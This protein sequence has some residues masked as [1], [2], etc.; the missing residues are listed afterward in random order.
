M[1]NRRGEVGP[2]EVLVA[3]IIIGCFAL[4]ASIAWNAYSNLRTAKPVVIAAEQSSRI[5]VTEISRFEDSSAYRGYRKVFLFHDNTTG[6]EWIGVTG[7]GVSEVGSHQSGK[8]R[9]EDE[10]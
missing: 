3:L 8:M 10:R 9:A 2:I 4:M 7:V 6:K 1:R 5:S